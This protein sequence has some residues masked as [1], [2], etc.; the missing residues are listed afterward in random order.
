MLS[1][2]SYVLATSRADDSSTNY[3][4]S[5]NVG[6]Y[7]T[8][9]DA[10]RH[11]LWNSL[12]AQY[13]F[14]I[15]S[16][17]K[18]LDFAE[19]VT[20][21]RETSPCGNFNE[22]DSREMD[23]HNNAIGR[24]IWANNTSYRTILGITWGLNR[25]STSHLKDLVR[26]S[27]EWNGLYIVKDHDLV[28]F[29]YSKEQVKAKILETDINT[30]VYFNKFIAPIR[31]IGSIELEYY[32]CDDGGDDF[33]PKQKSKSEELFSIVPDEGG[34]CFREIMVYTPIY[35]KFISI[36]TNFNPF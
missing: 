32:D 27:V 12:L 22:V 34:D 13:Y 7:N 8:R 21:A 2:I 33:I 36:D 16:K 18:R 35:P 28:G 14:T 10:Y 1:A 3:Y 4:S 30:P 20:N 31:Y 25:S 6:P 23:Y 29:R 11:I 26:E 19:F 5:R 15:S 24:S 9:R 17:S